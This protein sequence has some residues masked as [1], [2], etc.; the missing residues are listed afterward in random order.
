M[1]EIW[2]KKKLNVKTYTPAER[3]ELE[4]EEAEGFLEYAGLRII[5]SGGV[6]SLFVSGLFTGAL[7]FLNIKEQIRKFQRRREKVLDLRKRKK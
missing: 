5:E 4:K 2:R 6:M 1:R 7:G 3:L